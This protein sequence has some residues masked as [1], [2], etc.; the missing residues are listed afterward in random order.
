MKKLLFLIAIFLAASLF[1][2]EYRIV[3]SFDENALLLDATLTVNTAA[4]VFNLY[5]NLHNE[6]NPFVS[7]FQ[8]KP[9]GE[10][11]ILDV[12]VDGQKASYKLMKNEADLI[13]D[14]SKERT[15]LYIEAPEGK[16]T[17]TIRFRLHLPSGPVED[18]GCWEGFCCWRFGWYPIEAFPGN[19]GKQRGYVITPHSCSINLHLPRDWKLV[20]HSGMGLG[21]PL[22]LLKGYREYV[23]KGQYYTVKVHYLPGR[24]ERAEAIAAM[25]LNALQSIS[26]RFGKLDYSE[27]NVVQAPFSGLYGMTT[28]GVILMGDNAFTTAD[29]LAPGF[30]NPLVEF[31][32]LHESAHLWFGIGAAVDF[33]YDNF[34]SE[35]L[36]QYVSITQIEKEY[37]AYENL[38][39]KHT[40]D[41]FIQ[42]L[43][44]LFT[45]RS[46]RENYLYLY[47]SLWRQGLDGPVAGKE[48]YINQSV[49]LNYAK[50][51][52]GMRSLSLHFED[53][54]KVLKEYHDTFKHRVVSY[55]DFKNFLESKKKGASSLCDKLFLSNGS[56]SVSV[57]DEGEFITV[58]GPDIPYQIKVCT[59][60][61]GKERCFMLT[62]KGTAKLS[63]KSLVSVEADPN[64]LLPDPD[65]FDNSYPV[66]FAIASPF[67]SL[68]EATPVSPL[69]AYIVDDGF[70]QASFSD[71]EIAFSFTLGLRKFDEWG[72]YLGAGYTSHIDDQGNATITDY[73][74]STQGFITPNPYIGFS[75][76]GLTKVASSDISA[77]K[78][79]SGGLSLALPETVNI[80][81]TYPLVTSRN[82]I[83][84]SFTYQEGYF[85][86]A[87]L[88]YTFSDLVKLPVLFQLG[89]AYYVPIGFAPFTELYFFPFDFASLHLGG[90]YSLIGDIF[91][92]PGFPT[93]TLYSAWGVAEGALHLNLDLFGR[94]NILNVASLRGFILSLGS[95]VEVA[96]GSYG[97]DTMITLKTGLTLKL[98]SFLDTPSPFGLQLKIYINPTTGKTSSYLILGADVP[99]LVITAYKTALK[100]S[101]ALI[102]IPKPKL[103]PAKEKR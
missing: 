13:Q 30:I 42:Q 102:D 37:G 34:L 39:D 82:F 55:D 47:R 97:L 27:I 12:H 32:L 93:Y 21:C 49:P 84:L 24:K 74:L 81:Y 2:S 88:Y 63:K 6:R 23:L 90:I 41:L 67:I 59:Q 56:L 16:K 76:T 51:Y 14:Y 91:E 98:F 61:R 87:E 44:S 48:D 69:E 58:R 5:P 26:K 85:P 100:L 62:E 65:R 57:K 101:G 75:F 20:T 4:N 8:Q 10:I 103:P 33:T 86:E 77:L 52:F 68:E 43:S 22:V 95:G 79:F 18:E 70:L 35:S 64:W 54:D 96:N 71:N 53:F 94:T 1:P 72:L 92:P 15:L 60:E 25:E 3:G 50:G 9:T 38:Y 31:L 19:E 40:P 11:E 7:H 28:N 45:F 78:Y 83:D 17:I 80:G 29:L 89:S 66:K 36:A 99:E 46:L 73:L